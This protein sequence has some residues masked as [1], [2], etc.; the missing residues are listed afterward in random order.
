MKI[1]TVTR[2][3]CYFPMRIEIVYQG[4]DKDQA[5]RV[6]AQSGPDA[7]IHTYEEEVRE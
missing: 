4:H 6:K 2:P 1:Y 7:Q 3:F 5:E